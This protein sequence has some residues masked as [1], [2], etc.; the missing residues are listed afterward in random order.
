MTRRS[1]WLRLAGIFIPAFVANSVGKSRA[2]L[3][4][5]PLDSF[6][7][8]GRRIVLTIPARELSVLAGAERVSDRASALVAALKPPPGYRLHEH[9]GRVIFDSFANDGSLRAAYCSVL[10]TDKHPVYDYDTPPVMVTYR[11]HGKWQ[12]LSHT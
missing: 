4:A 12:E 10:Y 2:F 11:G 6:A 9:D 1:L 7:R 5:N 3:V 8:E